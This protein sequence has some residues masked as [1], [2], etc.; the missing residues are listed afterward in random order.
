MSALATRAF[1]LLPGNLQQARHI[2]PLPG[3]QASR[4]IPRR[5]T[6]SGGGECPGHQR[7]EHRAP[8]GKRPALLCYCADNFHVGKLFHCASV[9]GDVARFQRCNN[10]PSRVSERVWLVQPEHP[11]T[12]VFSDNAVQAHRSPPDMFCAGQRPGTLVPGL[13]NLPKPQQVWLAAFSS[14]NFDALSRIAPRGLT[15]CPRPFNVSVNP[16]QRRPSC[17]MFRSL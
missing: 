9:A 12:A 3:R 7:P 15:S 11:Y 14:A 10:I 17:S 1:L 6:P 2:I 16:L 8:P 4:G 13:P 5:Q